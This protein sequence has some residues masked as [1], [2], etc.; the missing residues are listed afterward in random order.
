MAESLRDQLVKAGLATAS[1]AKKAEKRLEAD[2]HARRRGK[3]AADKPTPEAPEAVKA[4]AAKQRAEKREKD[5]ALARATNEKAAAKAL[6]AEIRQLIL[7][8]DQ[9]AREARDDD[10]PYNFVHGKKIK[11]IHVPKAQLEQ[12][13]RGTLVIVNNDGLYHLVSKEVAEKI[14]ARDPRRII[15]AHDEKPP[16]PG[17]DDEYYAKFQVP[18]DLDW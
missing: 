17:S 2:R 3:P 14:R 10:L 6:R 4:R 7:Q 15:A 9:R 18:D 16:E 12:L 13:S 8:N 11:K 1:Q 5:R